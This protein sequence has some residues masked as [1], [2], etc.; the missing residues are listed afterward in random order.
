MALAAGFA[1]ADT[2]TFDAL[3]DSAGEDLGNAIASEGFIFFSD[4][5]LFAPALGQSA[6]A[7]GS[8]L[9]FLDAEQR[10]LVVKDG[11]VAFDLRSIDLVRIPGGGDGDGGDD[12]GDRGSND[13]GH[14]GDVTLQYLTSGSDDDFQTLTLHLGSSTDLTTFALDLDDITLFSLSGG[15]FQLDNV[16]TASSVPE[17]GSLAA[18]LAGLAMLATQARRRRN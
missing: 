2:V 3:R 7:V 8:T 5:H 1:A 12:I 14:N 9:A 17:P 11:I 13:D 4:A 15:P 16:V 10:L 18:L 6:D